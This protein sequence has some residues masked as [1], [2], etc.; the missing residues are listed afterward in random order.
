LAVRR[1]HRG[2]EYE[3]EKLSKSEW[4]WKIVEGSKLGP[5]IICDQIYKHPVKANISCVNQINS[6]LGAANDA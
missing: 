1:A 5:D 2:I 6:E 3:I 4:R